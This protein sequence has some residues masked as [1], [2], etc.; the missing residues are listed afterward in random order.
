VLYGKKDTTLACIREGDSLIIVSYD[1]AAKKVPVP[2]MS[3]SIDEQVAAFADPIIADEIHIKIRKEDKKKEEEKKKEETKTEESSMTWGQIFIRIGI[4]AGG[5]IVLLFLIPAFW[6]LCLLLR[7]NTAKNTKSKADA[8]YRLALYHF[9]MAGVERGNETPLQYAANK[10]EPAFKNGFVAFMNIFLRLKYANGQTIP[11]D[12]QV[13]QAFGKS[14][15]PAARKKAGGFKMILN[16]FNIFRAQRFF[17]RPGE[18]VNQE[19]EP[20]L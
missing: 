20:S 4:I 6:L 5:L 3:K 2:D 13:I 11:G 1:D 9:H 17:R 19:Q 8:A 18:T 16:Y 14:I 7:F 10:A 12:E 15:R